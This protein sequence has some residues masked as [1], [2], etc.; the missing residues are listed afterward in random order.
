VQ[1]AIYLQTLLNTAEFFVTEAARQEAAP[2]VR[3]YD[4]RTGLPL[5]DRDANLPDRIREAEADTIAHPRQHLRVLCA[6]IA[7]QHIWIGN[8]AA[9]TVEQRTRHIDA[10]AAWTAVARRNPITL[11]LVELA[12]LVQAAI[13]QSCDA[14]N[15]RR[16]AVEQ[17]E[18][19]AERRR[20]QALAY[21]GA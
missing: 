18:T 5:N 8:N 6:R 2:Q 15:I 4:E 11:P 14:A 3:Q 21:F 1:K 9:R 10:A 17:Q 7:Q 12:E 19:T 20:Q 16:R 13:K